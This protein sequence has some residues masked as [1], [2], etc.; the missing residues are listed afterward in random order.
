MRHLHLVK[1]PGETSAPVRRRRG[2]ADALRLTPEEVRAFRASVRNIAR[3]RYGSLAA[4]GR[5]L[6][7][8][9][10][11]L[12]KRKRPGGA[13]VIAVWRLTGIPVETLLRPQL[14]AVPAPA[15]ATGGGAA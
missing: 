3:E 9:A 1:P 8:R 11:I 2:Q 5:A 12:T 7:V 15:P 10:S 6:G 13:L 14:A 4:L